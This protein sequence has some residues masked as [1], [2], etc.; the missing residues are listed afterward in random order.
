MEDHY[1]AF[2]WD[3]FSFS[4]LFT[5]CLIFYQNY[6][7]CALTVLP[8]IFTFAAIMVNE[9]RSGCLA[10]GILCLCWPFIYAAAFHC[11][12]AVFP[13]IPNLLFQLLPDLILGIAL[14]LF[15]LQ[16]GF[17]S[18][19]WFFLAATVFNRIREFINIAVSGQSG[20]SHYFFAFWPFLLAD[21]AGVLLAFSL[22]F[23]SQTT[24]KSGFREP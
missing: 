8:L 5:L 3:G 13:S 23:L 11:L 12:Y 16:R 24:A 18:V 19:G 2:A 22:Q 15:A 4:V 10:A 6:F 1:R 7:F 9:K 21:F 20:I 14:I 17:L